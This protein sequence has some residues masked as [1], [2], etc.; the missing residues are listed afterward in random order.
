MLA[1]HDPDAVLQMDPEIFPSL[2]LANS[3]II[4]VCAPD[5]RGAR[6]ST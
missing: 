1:F 4:P 2:H 3:E 5:A 6:C